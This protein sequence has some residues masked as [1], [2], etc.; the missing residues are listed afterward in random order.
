MKQVF[1]EVFGHINL[2][3]KY[4]ETEINFWGLQDKTAGFA[5]ASQGNANFGIGRGSTGSDGAPRLEQLY[6][7]DVQTAE[8]YQLA[9]TAR[10]VK[11][12]AEDE[13]QHARNLKQEPFNQISMNY[14]ET[15]RVHRE[16][17]LPN[18]AK[19]TDN[20]LVLTEFRISDAQ[21]LALSNYLDQTQDMSSNLVKALHID[22]CGMTDHQFSLILQGLA[23]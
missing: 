7:H 2:G 18:F 15:L 6:N 21:A 4:K 5:L 9:K 13:E 20:V 14:Y 16:V 22:D 17:P 11:T 23:A 10:I 12:D 1:E 3:T 19:L 8:F